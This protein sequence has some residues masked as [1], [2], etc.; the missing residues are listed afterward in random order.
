M[1]GD[2]RRP[3]QR[4]PH[5]QHLVR[6][7]AGRGPPWHRGRTVLIGDAAHACPP[8]IAQGAAM[9]LEDAAVLAELLTGR[10]PDPL[11]AFHARRL[12]R[13]RAVVEASIQLCR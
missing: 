3:R 2:P 4:R 13:V 8:T 6:V 10:T 1:E 12:P 11:A 7:A 5:Q 9:C